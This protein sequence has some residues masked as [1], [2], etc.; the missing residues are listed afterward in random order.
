MRRTP[1]DRLRDEM[2]SAPDRVDDSHLPPR[3]AETRTALRD[4][5]KHLEAKGVSNGTIV[6][7]MLSE[8][9]PRMVYERG[10]AG[11]AATLS[12]IADSLVHQPSA[13]S[14]Q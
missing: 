9:L 7:A 12:K 14:R 5:I 6:M 11:A 8:T 3:F 10:P 13:M 1:M 4:A 2:L